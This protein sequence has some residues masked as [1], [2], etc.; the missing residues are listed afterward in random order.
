[1]HR[2]HFV[3]LV[4]LAPLLVSAPASAAPILD[5]VCCSA[6]ALGGGD[7]SLYRFQ[8]FTVG[9]NGTM[10]GIEVGLGGASLPPTLTLYPTAFVPGQ[11]GDTFGTP[12]ILNALLAN[13]GASVPGAGT[14]T[15][16]FASLGLGIAVTVGQ[17]F[18]ILLR[19]GIAGLPIY[20]GDPYPGGQFLSGVG[21]NSLLVTSPGLGD[22]PFRTYV[23]T[24][25]APIPEPSTFLMIGGGL[26]ALVRGRSRRR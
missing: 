20:G 1:M 13:T 24:A 6:V 19:D 3:V 9:L 15:Y 5:Q 18:T 23:D 2:R 7:F 10:T 22:F 16:Y 8:T 17:Q 21:P 4:A 14:S 11:T 26:A 25:P 12:L